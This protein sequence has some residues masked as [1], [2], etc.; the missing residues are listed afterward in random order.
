MKPKIEWYI[1]KYIQPYKKK[2]VWESWDGPFRSE[3]IARKKFDNLYLND[4]ANAKRQDFRI[5]KTTTEL[6]PFVFKEIEDDT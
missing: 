1:E 2:G 5:V 4:E 3:K 6:V